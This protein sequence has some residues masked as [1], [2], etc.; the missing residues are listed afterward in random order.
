ML[1]E[2]KIAQFPLFEELQIHNIGHQSDYIHETL[3]GSHN[4]RKGNSNQCDRALTTRSEVITQDNFS[5]RKYKIEMV[6]IVPLFDSYIWLK[7][8]FNE[9]FRCIACICIVFF[10]KVMAKCTSKRPTRAYLVL[11]LKPRHLR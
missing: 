5:Q 9:D 4:S 3:V 10:S 6:V 1:I 8:T 2:P 11:V 7:S